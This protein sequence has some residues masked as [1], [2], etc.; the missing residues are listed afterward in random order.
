MKTYRVGRIEHAIDKS[1][2][3]TLYVDKNMNWYTQKAVIV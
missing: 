3:E 2:N 1:D